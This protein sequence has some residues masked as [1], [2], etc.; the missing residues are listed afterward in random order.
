MYAFGDERGR[1]G[2]GKG[3][4]CF[5]GVGGFFLPF[6][7][8]R[9]SCLKGSVNVDCDRLVEGTIKDDDVLDPLERL[10]TLVVEK[11]DRALTQKWGLWLVRRDLERGLKV[12][13][14]SSHS[15]IAPEITWYFSK[16]LLIPRETGKRREKPEEDIALLNQIEEANPAAGVQ[17]LEYLVLR[18]RSNVCLLPSPCSLSANE[19][20]FI[21]Y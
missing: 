6:A 21:F 5:E 13:F 19:K 8:F 4:G 16:Q 2:Q 10:V 12:S 7:L 20:I 11:K 17:Y 9:F 3:V 1:G 18:R 15:N 14:L